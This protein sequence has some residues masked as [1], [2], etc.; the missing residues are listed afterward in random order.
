M[1]ILRKWTTLALVFAL[2]ITSVQSQPLQVEEEPP[3][4]A[5]YTQSH[6]AAHWSAYIPIGIMVAAAIWFGV[7]DQQPNNSDSSFSGRSKYRSKSRSGSYSSKSEY[8]SGS[9]AHY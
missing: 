7:A 6:Q 9:H 1:Q 4:S 3:Y 2:T 8:S 5:A